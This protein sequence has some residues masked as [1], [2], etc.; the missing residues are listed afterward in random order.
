M[1]IDP[2]GRLMMEIGGV[3][4]LNKPH[5]IA[6]DI[7]NS[8]YV[9]DTGN[10]RLIKFNFNGM[11]IAEWN[12]QNPVSVSLDKF[13]YVYVVN[14]KDRNIKIID[15]NGNFLIEFGDQYLNE[16]FDIAIDKEL[17][18]YITDILDRDIEVFRIITDI[19]KP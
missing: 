19:E 12:I 11:Q 14:Q 13:G 9:C 17:R 5:G 6:V 1:K 10:N 8:I 2:L 16:P 4:L 15:P 7:D 18:A 3:G